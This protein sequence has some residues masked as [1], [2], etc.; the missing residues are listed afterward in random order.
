MHV[1][2]TRRKCPERYR[3]DEAETEIILHHLE[4]LFQTVVLWSDMYAT[5]ISCF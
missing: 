4:S 1:V 3:K 5:R 2:G